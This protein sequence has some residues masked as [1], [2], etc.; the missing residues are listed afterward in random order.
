M[1][2]N[3]SNS[4]WGP[5][6]WLG[7]GKTTLRMGGGGQK[8][9]LIEFKGEFLNESVYFFKNCHLDQIFCA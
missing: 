2:K 7:I 5:L 3:Q 6:K 8:G 4:A 1:L 9:R